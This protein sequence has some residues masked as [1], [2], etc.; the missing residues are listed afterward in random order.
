M[1]ERT[2]TP[3]A[4]KSILDRKRVKIL[5]THQ[6]LPIGE[7][8]RN[9]FPWSSVIAARIEGEGILSFHLYHAEFYYG[10]SLTLT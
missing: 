9:V 5:N 3:E 6:Y 2:N 10:I 1:K 4:N 8:G 7:V